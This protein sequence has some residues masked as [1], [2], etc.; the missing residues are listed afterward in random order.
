[1]P[2]KSLPPSRSDRRDKRRGVA[3]PPATPAGESAAP[4]A[5]P[6]LGTT[7]ATAGIKTPISS[8]RGAWAP[9]VRSSA[10]GGTIHDEEYRYIYGDLRRIGILAGSAFVVL[11]ALTFVL[12]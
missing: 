6:S 9:V 11:I 4:V 2:K 1:M 7:A 8:A 5:K 10:R 12:R 3:R